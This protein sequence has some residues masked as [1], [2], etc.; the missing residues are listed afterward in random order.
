MISAPLYYS[1]VQIT[2]SNLINPANFAG[3]GGS[4]VFLSGQHIFI[5]GGIGEITL[6]QLNSLSGFTTDISGYL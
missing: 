4:L 3:L 1:K 6:N 2:G 5:S